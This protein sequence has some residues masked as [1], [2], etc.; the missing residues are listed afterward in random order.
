MCP[1]SAIEGI[2]VSMLGGLM[3]WNTPNKESSPAALLVILGF[4]PMDC[5]SGLGTKTNY[6]VKRLTSTLRTNKLLN[7][8]LHLP[9]FHPLNPSQ[10]EVAKQDN[11]Y[12]IYLLIRKIFPFWRC[13]QIETPKFSDAT[14]KGGRPALACN[15]STALIFVDAM[16]FPPQIPKYQL[17]CQN[18]KQNTW[19][20]EFF[21]GISNLEAATFPDPYGNLRTK[22]KEKKRGRILER[23]WGELVRCMRPM[24][25]HTSLWQCA[26]AL[27]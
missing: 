16:R 18:S 12:L 22:L 20:S 6:M 15:R 9:S 17:L 11:S 19:E 13:R 2:V 1:W 8:F 5:S 3:Q 25:I 27:D 26:M 7:K 14:F 23:C 10:R 24:N 21:G 4:Q